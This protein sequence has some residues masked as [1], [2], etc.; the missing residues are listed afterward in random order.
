MKM[1]TEKVKLA[2]GHLAPNI[3]HT[4]AAYSRARKLVEHPRKTKPRSSW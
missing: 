3:R 4:R 1:R 2:S